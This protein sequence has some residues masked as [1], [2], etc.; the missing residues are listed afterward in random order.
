MDVREL[1]LSRRPGFSKRALSEGLAAAGIAYSHA[2]ALGT[3]RAMRHALKAGGSLDAFR[4]AYAKHLATQEAALDELVDVASRERCALLCVERD[5]AECHRD[6]VAR[7]LEERGW[8]VT[9][10]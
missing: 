1:P 2:K 6:V 10:L 8:A 4:A 9:H 3:P 5:H 7:A